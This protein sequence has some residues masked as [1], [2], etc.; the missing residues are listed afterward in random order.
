MKVRPKPIEKG[1]FNENPDDRSF[2]LIIRLKEDIKGMETKL[3]SQEAF[4]KEA[5]TIL[6]EVRDIL[7][8]IR[9]ADLFQE[10]DIDSDDDFEQLKNIIGKEKSICVVEFFAGSNIYIP[11]SA[12][13]VESYQ[14]I[15]KEYK[16]GANYRELSVKYGYTERHI[17]N[18]IHRKKRLKNGKA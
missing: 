16:D 11:K 15:R 17:R 10:N 3:K 12:Q 4:L 9:Q 7:Y 18:I 6:H 2:E 5:G 13:T 8:E 1:L 14:A